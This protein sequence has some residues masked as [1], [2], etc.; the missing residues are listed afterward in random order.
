MG[1]SQA[2]QLEGR[3]RDAFE[4]PTDLSREAVVEISSER[5]R[6]LADVFALYVKTKNF[7]ASMAPGGLDAPEPLYR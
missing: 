3:E 7:H 1:K 5:R 4:T 2:T 6:L